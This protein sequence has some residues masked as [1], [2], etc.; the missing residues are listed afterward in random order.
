MAR[1]CQCRRHVVWRVSTTSRQRPRTIRRRRPLRTTLHRHQRLSHAVSSFFS[2]ALLSVFPEGAPQPKPGSPGR[3]GKPGSDGRSGQPGR[4]GRD[5]D[6]GLDGQVQRN[7]GGGGYG[8]APV[9]EACVKCNPG[10]RGAP[11]T[12]YCALGANLN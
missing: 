4:P 7:D 2:I 1:S 9:N 12:H 10:P 11:G 3:P 6:D 8:P 5:G